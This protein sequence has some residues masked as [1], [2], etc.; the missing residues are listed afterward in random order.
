MQLPS[1]TA[2]VPPAYG[3]ATENADDGRQ[4]PLQG[5]VP[6][7]VVLTDMQRVRVAS[8]TEEINMTVLAVRHN[9]GI[10][11][12]IGSYHIIRCRMGH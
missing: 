4:Q 1:L 9:C 11:S 5:L 12:C 6:V 7:P 2:V 10:E 8:S 3:Q